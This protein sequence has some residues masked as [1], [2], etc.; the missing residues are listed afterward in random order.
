M[1]LEHAERIYSSYS[2]VYDLFFDTILHPGRVRAVEVMDPRAGDEVLEVGVG[3][4][5][6][7][8]LYPSHCHVTGIDISEGM[9]AKAQEKVSD[10]RL[11]HVDLRKMSAEALTFDTGTFDLAL[12]SYVISCVSR[13]EAVLSEVARVVR[14]GGRVIFLNHFLS[15]NRLKAWC[16]RRLTPLSRRLG[17]V[18]DLPLETV[19]GS[20][21]YSLELIERVNLLGQWSLVSCV[22]RA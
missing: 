6:S 5:L 21:A 1:A 18:L 16:E 2:S 3:T 7:L 19:T 8:P 11:R 17:F 15:P 9:L 20:G 14:P 22:R 4:G 12:L 13:P 10:Q